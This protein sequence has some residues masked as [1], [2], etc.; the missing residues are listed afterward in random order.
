M[1]RDGPTPEQARAHVM[2]LDSTGLLCEGPHKTEA[3]KNDSVQTA[4]L[5]QSF[6]PDVGVP[7][8]L[9][10]IKGSGATCLIGLGGI[11]GQFTEGIVMAV[12]TNCKIPLSNPNTNMDAFPKD[13][14]KWMDNRALIACGSPLDGVP[15]PD[16]GAAP[17]G[18]GDNAFVFPVLGAGAVCVGATKITDNMVMEGGYTV[19]E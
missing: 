15:L 4:E 6:A 19:A 3:Y 1:L 16:D 18:Q 5:A 14:V 11:P 12:A 7:D 2:A 9:P 17:I 8:L 10:T 13:I